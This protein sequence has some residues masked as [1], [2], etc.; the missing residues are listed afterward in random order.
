MIFNAGF[1]TDLT[2]TYKGM[3]VKVTLEFPEQPDWR[4]E[5]EF[6]GRLKAVYLEKLEAMAGQGEEAS[7][8]YHSM[9]NKEGCSVG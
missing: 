6:T 1:S 3:P 8:L 7:F 4:A 2:L 9:E 5:E